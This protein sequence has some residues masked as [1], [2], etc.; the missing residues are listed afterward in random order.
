MGA[1]LTLL[2]LI[3]PRASVFHSI[4]LWAAPVSHETDPAVSQDLIHIGRCLR[5]PLD[6]RVPPCQNSPVTPS[7]RSCRRL[8]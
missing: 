3:S 4:A 5:V 7:L 8:P 1:L 2:T 6:R